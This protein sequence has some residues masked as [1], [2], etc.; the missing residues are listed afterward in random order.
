MR[1]YPH[2]RCPAVASPHPT[3]RHPVEAFGIPTPPRVFC[4]KSLDLLDCEGVD[5]FGSDKET[6]S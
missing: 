2:P 1:G 6:A 5:F 4:K 3:P